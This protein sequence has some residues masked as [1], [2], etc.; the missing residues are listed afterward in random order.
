[1]TLKQLNKNYIYRTDKE[2]YGVDEYWEE[3]KPSKEGKYIGDC[4]SYA[5]TVRRN[6]EGFENWDY[7]WCTLSGNGHCM[8]S[9]GKFMIDNNT[10]EVWTIDKYT[11]TFI[12][13][14]LRPFRWYELAIKFI[15]AKLL[16]IWFKLRR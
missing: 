11:S 14:E 2:Q 10:K 16:S 6:I 1:M 12:V 4:E 5:I 7:Y 8:L 13:D 9:D 15:Q 3:M